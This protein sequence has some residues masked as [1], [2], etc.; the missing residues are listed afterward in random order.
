MVVEI[1]AGEKRRKDNQI[2]KIRVEEKG[3]GT[4][5]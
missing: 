2:Q 4:A 1:R 3:E 5:G